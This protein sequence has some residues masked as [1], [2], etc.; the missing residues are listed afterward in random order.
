MAIDTGSLAFV[1]ISA[2]MVFFM[3]PGVAF[4]YAGLMDIGCVVSMMLQIFVAMG[5]VTLWWWFIGFSLCFGASGSVIGNPG[6][7]IALTGV[8]VQKNIE[9][10]GTLIGGIPGMAFCIFQLA[11]A[12]VTPT[13][14]TGAF[15]ERLSFKPYIVF[16]L[17][18]LTLVYAPWAHMTWG[19]GLAF[20]NGLLDFAGGTVIHVTAG[21][22]A[23]GLCLF[24]GKRETVTADNPGE[25]PHSI[26]L[27]LIGTAILWFGWF[28]FN[29]GSALGS[30]SVA[31]A[32]HINSQLSAGAALWVWLVIDWLVLG[33]P[34]LVGACI[35]ALV[36]LIAVTP[37]S[38]F[39]QPWAAIVIGTLCAGFSQ[40]ACWLRKRYLLQWFDDTVDVWGTHGVAGLIGSCLVGALADSSDCRVDASLAPEWCV[41][42]G[43][44]A[45]VRSWQQFGIQILVNLIAAV[46]S[47]IVSYL[48]MLCMSKMMELKPGRE[49][50]SVDEAEHG[51]AA[52]NTPAKTS[53]AV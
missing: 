6:T 3:T 11:F 47:T 49:G 5:I 40:L 31:C 17:L 21:W 50:E 43:P 46:Y 44:A 8:N 38:G 23:L 34:S 25:K 20:K 42:P 19:G 32:A 1:L 7:Y 29:A 45:G 13:L 41:N 2:S 9:I 4:L 30:T 15:S 18:W 10:N 16:T 53:V 22:S 26:P 51:E 48:L 24:L 52:Y 27:V 37:G 14:A 12:I 39:V 33:K 36:G 28:G 35:G